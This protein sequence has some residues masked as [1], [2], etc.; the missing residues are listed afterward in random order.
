MEELKSL[1]TNP[2]DK[3]NDLNGFQDKCKEIAKKLLENYCIEYGEKKYYY[4]AEIEFYY[5]D[6][7][8][9]NDEWNEKTYPRDKKD[10]GDFFFHYSGVD[11]CFNSKFEEGKFGGILIRSLKDKN[12]NFITGPSV[13]MLE[14]LNTC[15]EQKTNPILVKR[16]NEGCSFSE[17][18]IAR[19]GITYKDKQEDKKLC[20]Y[21]ERLKEK[22]TNEFENATWDYSK[23]KNG[24]VKGI[25]KITRYYKKRFETQ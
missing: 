23:K 18:P 2:F 11:I 10:A 4:F 16:K 24:E 22:L 8:R 17:Q 25:K 5:Y 14:I 20:F 7:E 13:C 1:L 6:K 21:D 3:K 9:W 15:F 19:Y 12:G